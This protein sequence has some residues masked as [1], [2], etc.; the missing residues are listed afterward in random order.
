MK[1]RSKPGKSKKASARVT[2]ARETS[3]AGARE[4]R[5]TT[6]G[7]TIGAGAVENAS[8]RQFQKTRAKAIQAHILGRGQRRQAKR[9]AR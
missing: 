9:D 6:R 5:R 1:P 3:A 7:K 2:A 4:A 8:R